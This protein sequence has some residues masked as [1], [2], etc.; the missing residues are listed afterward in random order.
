MGST[1]FGV[2]L[3]FVIEGD[4]GMACL[5]LGELSSVARLLWFDRCRGDVVGLVLVLG[6]AW[7]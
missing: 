3:V 5:I 6:Y 2:L 7:V 4:P 1:R